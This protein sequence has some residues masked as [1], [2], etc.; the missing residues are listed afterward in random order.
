MNRMT[1]D[2]ARSFAAASRLQFE[3]SRWSLDLAVLALLAIATP[4]LLVVLCPGIFQLI[5][6]EAMTRASAL[7]APAAFGV[8][9]LYGV[10]AMVASFAA[11]FGVADAIEGRSG[12]PAET[13]KRLAVCLGLGGAATLASAALS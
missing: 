9:L 11:L 8:S 13:R 10:I 5:A 2:A 1:V 6:G 3:N 7:A 12:F 4:F